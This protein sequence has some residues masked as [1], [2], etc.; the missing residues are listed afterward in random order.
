MKSIELILREEEEL[1]FYSNQTIEIIARNYGEYTA[2]D[3]ALLRE[4]T[5]WIKGNDVE[6]P[7][8]YKI[9]EAEETD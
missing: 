3:I 9:K 7:K 1:P 2:S 8:Y 5:M 6:C 4:L